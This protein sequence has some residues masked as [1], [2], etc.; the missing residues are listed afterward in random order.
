MTA[1]PQLARP[2]AGGAIADLDRLVVGLEEVVRLGDQV[3]PADVAARLVE[4]HLWWS[5]CAEAVHHDPARLQAWYSTETTELHLIGQ[6][7]EPAIAAARVVAGLGVALRRAASG[8]LNDIAHEALQRAVTYWT[9]ANVIARTPSR[10]GVY[11]ASGRNAPQGLDVIVDALDAMAGGTARTLVALQAASLA[12]A[13]TV[14][15]HRRHIQ[16]LFEIDQHEVVGATGTISTAVLPGGPSGLFPDPRDM[17]FF[18]ADDSFADALTDAWLS[19]TRD[20]ANPPCVL[21][22][23]AHDNQHGPVHGDSLG[24]AFAVALAETLAAAK[25]RP[26]SPRAVLQSARSQCAVTGTVSSHGHIGPVAGLETKF[27]VARPRNWR[28]VAPSANRAGAERAKPDG[29]RVAWVSTVD[30]ARRQVRRWRPVR[31][32]L[33]ATAL[34][35][36]LLVAGNVFIVK[37]VIERARELERELT[38]KDEVAS[39]RNLI[40]QS[41]LRRDRQHD[42]ALRLGVAAMELDPGPPSRS[43]L[44]STI[45][46]PHRMAELS[47]GRPSGPGDSAEHERAPPAGGGR[48]RQRHQPG[49]VRVVVER[50]GPGPARPSRGPRHARGHDADGRAHGERADRRHHS[51]WR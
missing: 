4:G 29:L 31:T 10:S 28:V 1:D 22:T 11:A 20:G 49:R 7:G 51:A 47:A 40:L 27:K 37:G 19:A 17:S 34:A 32:A 5:A 9:G 18:R 30:A 35:A 42:D 43:S 2:P 36:A 14:T 13:P 16:V 41:D 12:G 21:W 23:V 24:A 50:G 38:R 25:R 3:T 45:L 33:A 39:A 15:R 26:W 6:F 44:I 8:V 48:R 46:A